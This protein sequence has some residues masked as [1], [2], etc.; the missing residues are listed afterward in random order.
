ME[1]KELTAVFLEDGFALDYVARLGMGYDNQGLKEEFNAAPEHALFTLNFFYIREHMPPPLAFL[2]DLSSMFAHALVQDP[3]IELTREAPKLPEAYVETAL[4][5]VPFALGNHY[6]DDVWI[7]SRYS[8]MCTIFNQEISAYDGTVQRY[9]E[10]LSPRLQVAGRVFFHLVE[11]KMDAYPFAFL[12]T[13]STLSSEG[14]SHYPLK[15]ALAEFRGDDDALLGL[16][17]TVTKAA[18]A[19]DFMSELVES[20]EIFSP[21]GFTAL[22]AFTFLKEIPLY[23]ACGIMCRIPNWW[24]KQSH[25]A[26]LALELGDKMPSHVGLDALISFDVRLSLGDAELSYEELKVLL[27]QTE[28]LSL[29]KGRW[30]EINH[31]KL[32]QVLDAYEK[33]TSIEELSLGDA[34]RL[35]L[36]PEASFGGLEVGKSIE[37]SN[38][39]WLT[40]FKDKRTVQALAKEERHTSA[41]FNAELRHYQQFGFSWLSS[42]YDFG[43]GALL[44]DDM[45]LGKTVQVLALLDALRPLKIKTILV[46][47]ASLIGN[48]EKECKRFAP[49][50]RYKVVHAQ[51]REFSLEEADLFITT[52]GMVMRLD[53]LREPTWDIV[54]L[55][56][57][58]AIKN[59]A[60]KQTKAIKA[61]KARVRVALTGTPVENRL[62]DLWSLFDFLNKGLLGSAREFKEFSTRMNSEGS[63]ERLRDM[64]SPFILRRL[65][66]DKNIIADLPEKTE[67]KEF[68]NLSKKQA[69]LYTKIV[70][71]L[72]VKLSEVEGIARRGLVLASIMRLKQLCNHPDQYLGMGDYAQK[73]SGK[74]EKL[75]ELCETIR[76]KHERVLVFT[77]FREIAESLSGFLSVQFGR[78]G[79]VLHGGTP[80]KKRTKLVDAFNGAEYVPFMVLSLKA[81]GVG[82]NLTGANH[83]IHFDRWWNP[84][85]E[86]QATDRAF[87]IGQQKN[88][89]V[90]KLITI[91]TIEEK[92]DYLLEEKSRLAGEVIADT[93][94]AWITEL[95][96]DELLKLFTLET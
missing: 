74:F 69:V 45:G 71:E 81:G 53:G 73:Q 9:L 88:V 29:L 4:D 27:A 38:G 91:G 48:W 35:Q 56:E 49:Q 82:L 42:M 39:S 58:Q 65:K 84:A 30:V 23:E 66:T 16:L 87:R 43:L 61:L 85:V 68:V 10:K 1:N 79:L 37:I 95:P 34:M 89:F 6:I 62:S 20:G 7:I 72:A 24:K 59:P 25:A 46:I 64:V 5:R 2:Y 32:Q 22:E 50:L 54:V 60:T 17:A 13:Y 40:A 21:L 14:L 67:V 15:N 47:P 80:I 94:E 86:N 28:G 78:Q 76:E 12:A 96:N 18:D 51:S 19:S 57:A 11:S 36:R 93:S 63:Y 41:E 52:Y 33:A 44:G 55:D 3:D 70:Q 75:A 8:E 26:R 77:Q 83:V 92:I 31:E 90:H